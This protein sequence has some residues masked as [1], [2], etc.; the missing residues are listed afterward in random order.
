MTGGA[1][2]RKNR[3]PGRHVAGLRLIQRSDSSKDPQ[4]L[5]VEGLA[6]PLDDAM[7][8]DGR[9]RQRGGAFGETLPWVK[10]IAGESA[11]ALDA[12]G[13]VIE[14]GVAAA[15]GAPVEQALVFHIGE[16]VE[17]PV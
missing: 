15:D 10:I 8:V 9:V 2:G 6:G 4:S 5:R 3:S 7:V 17:H 12:P 1:I 11:A 13:V 14:V 16:L